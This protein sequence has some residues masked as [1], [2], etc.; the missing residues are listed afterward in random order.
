MSRASVLALGR[1]KAEAGMADACTITR[2]GAT[3]APVNGHVAPA[4]V[5][6]IYE[7]PC[8]VQEIFGFGREVNPSP[9]Q[10]RLARYRVLQLPVVTSVRRETVGS[11]VGERWKVSHFPSAEK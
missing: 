5:E 1:T 6:T 4:D 3:T 10:P 11:S 9:D 8:R 7:G 2:V